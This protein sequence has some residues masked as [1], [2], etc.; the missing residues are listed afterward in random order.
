MPLRQPDVQT[1]WRLATLLAKLCTSQLGSPFQT[2]TRRL[3][4]SSAV[5]QKESRASPLSLECNLWNNS[6]FHTNR[7]NDAKPR[8]LA[9]VEPLGALPVRRGV[10][11][12]GEFGAPAPGP[13]SRLSCLF[14]RLPSANTERKQSV[15]SC[16]IVPERQSGASPIFP[17]P[18]L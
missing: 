11:L 1:L 17:I 10:A 6:G 15:Q 3:C 2:R 14:L 8:S 13:S 9:L 18:S 5:L 7:R 16:N 12:T 4:G